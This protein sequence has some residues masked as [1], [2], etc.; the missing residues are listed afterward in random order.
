MKI[1]INIGKAQLEF[2]G[3]DYKEVSKEAS[4]FAQATKC[5]CCQSTN[6]AIDFHSAV[7]KKGQNVGQSFDYYA[8][9]CM[10]CWAKAQLGQFKTGGWFVKKWEKFES[11]R[12]QNTQQQNVQNAEEVFDIN[13]NN[14]D[15]PF[16]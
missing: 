3:R 13:P 6:V 4:A 8:V 15:V 16:S 9:K 14:G 1:K 11:N 10:D 5:G 7:A 12:T 2:E